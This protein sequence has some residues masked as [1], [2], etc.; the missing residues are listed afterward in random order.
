M[1]LKT[2]RIQDGPMGFVRKYLLCNHPH[3]RAIIVMFFTG[4]LNYIQGYGFTQ[5]GKPINY[6]MFFSNKH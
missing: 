2:R 5:D 3:K 4:A 1:S 6:N